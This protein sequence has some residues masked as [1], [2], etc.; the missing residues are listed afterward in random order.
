[1]IHVNEPW[2]GKEEQALANTALESGWISG[3]GQFIDRFERGWADVCERRHGVAVCNGTAAIETAIHALGLP[4]GSEVILPTFTI[5]AC[6]AGVLRNGLVPVCV[7]AEPETWCM[8]VGQVEAAITSHTRA[9]LVVHTYGHPVDMDPLL[10][11]ARRHDLKIIEDAA[12]AHGARD[13]GRICGSFG[14]A[15]VFSF[16]SN[17]IVTTGEGGMVVCDDDA[18]ADASRNYRNLYFGREERFRHEKL[19]HNY[20][21]NNL[22]AAIGCAQID[23]LPEALTRKARMGSL[24]SEL[25]SDTPDLQLPPA[26]KDATTTNVHWVYGV[27]VGDSYPF[28]ADEVRRRLRDAGV[29][30]RSFFLGLHEQPALLGQ[31][32]G[33]RRSFPVAERLARRGLYLPSGLTITEEQIHSVAQA[34]RDALAH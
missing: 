7:D 2:I 25:L 17:K 9:I 4:T 22:Q 24:Y 29:D 20:R 30:S 33:E 8:D 27:V 10:Q 11:L 14:D 12:E 16:Y 34:L 5:V 23:K 28:E 19:G 15:S 21:F 26:P 3:Q 6:A 31:F 1:L 13:R 32:G 18:V